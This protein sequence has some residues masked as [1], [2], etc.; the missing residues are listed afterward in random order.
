MPVKALDDLG[1]DGL[2][3]AHDLAQVF[4]VEVARE[5]S[6][7]HQGAKHDRELATLG[8]RGMLDAGHSGSWGRMGFL[9]LRRW[10]PVGWRR[11]GHW[12][13]GTARPD[14]HGMVLVH[15]ESEHLDDFGFQIVKVGVI[16]MKLALEG[17]IRHPAPALEH[18]E[19]AIQ[20]LL[21]GHRPPSRS[22]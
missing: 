4:G 3:G 5:P 20:H 9:R 22:R 7:V 11:G 15:S 18:V 17:P 21:K 13:A 16:E 12:C 1:T 2:V 19:G 8:L 6:R 14:Q 10:R